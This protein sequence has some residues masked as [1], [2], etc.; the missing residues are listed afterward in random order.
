MQ[1]N[2]FYKK[3]LSENSAKTLQGGLRKISEKLS[4][5]LTKRTLEETKQKPGKK[6][7]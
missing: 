4:K 6:K 1:Y 7:S 3:K 5:N 2:F